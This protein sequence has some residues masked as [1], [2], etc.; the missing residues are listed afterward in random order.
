MADDFIG[1]KME[2]Y[3][4]RKNSPATKRK[5]S[6]SLSSLLLKN[7]SYRSYDKSF[8]VRADQLRSIIEV[9]TKIASARNGQTLRFRP[10]LANEA[11][12]VL[13]HIR[14]G[15]ALPDLE[16]P[17]KGYEPQS[18]IVVCSTKTPT[19]YTYIDLGISAQSMLLRAVEIGLNGICIAAFDKSIIKKELQLPF[20]PLLILAI[21]KG[22]E[23]IQL[24]EA[25]DK[26]RLDY[27][28]N[29]NTHYVPKLGIDDIIIPADDQD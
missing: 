28:R 7:R 29:D 24:T 14:L 26:S 2:D 10:V 17:P 25:T 18:F 6:A 5:S 9:N 23:Q 22:A 3:L 8:T 16:L 20:E 4:A 21:G 15:A 11:I 12:K 1:K 27:Y 19:P 13:P